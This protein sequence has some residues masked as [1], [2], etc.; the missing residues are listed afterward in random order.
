MF[1]KMLI[2]MTALALIAGVA[3]K[4]E[5]AD[6]T[7]TV[8]VTMQNVAVSVSPDSWAIGA[9]EASSVTDPESFTATNDGNVSEDLVISVG[10]SANWTAE[11]SA[12]ANKFVMELD[13]T[14]ALSGTPISLQAGVAGGGN[15]TFNLVFTAPSSSTV[16]TEQSITVTISASAS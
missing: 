10:P 13:G 7:I 14:T 9:V 1:K 5:A 11:A 8:T 2:C 15:K 3:M 16:Y 6:A 4:A 12:D